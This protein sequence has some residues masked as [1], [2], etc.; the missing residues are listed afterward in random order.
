MVLGNFA[1]L[2]GLDPR[3]VNA[4]FLGVYADAF[5]WVELPNVTGMT[6]FADGGYLASKPYAASGAYINRMSTYC[7]NCRYKVAQKNG[8]D[9]CPFNYLYWDFLIRNQDKLRSNPRMGMPYRT[10][11]KMDAEKINRITSDSAAFLK[12]MEQS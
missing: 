10:L 9:A 2:A 11:A 4:W 12:K 7:K 6:L 5:E 3:E 8:E 1:L